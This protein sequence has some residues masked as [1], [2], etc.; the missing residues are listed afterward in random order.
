MKTKNMLATSVLGVFMLVLMLY[1]QRVLHGAQNGISIVFNTLL[2][3]LFPF[4]LLSMF[5]VNTNLSEK[6]FYYPSLLLS[7]ITRLDKSIFPLLFIGNLGGYPCCAS[8]LR[9]YYKNGQIDKKDAEIIS[10]V[11][12][13]GGPA[14]LI[15]TVGCGL[16]LSTSLGFILYIS[17]LLS[18][19]TLVCMVHQRTVTQDESTC[20]TYILR[21]LYF[22]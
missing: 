2:P 19:L 18:S 12:T 1:P 16:F 7:H 22:G 11:F 4:M 20:N 3:S 14:F 13:G 17:S 21:T 5:L 9:A 6:L 15:S 10:C 8:N